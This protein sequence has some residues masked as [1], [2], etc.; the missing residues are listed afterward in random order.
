MR[1]TLLAS[2]VWHRSNCRIASRATS[3]PVEAD[4]GVRGTTSRC[5]D[6]PESVLEFVGGRSKRRGARG[7]TGALLYV[8]MQRLKVLNLELLRA[9]AIVA[10]TFLTQTQFESGECGLASGQRPSRY[11]AFDVLQ[12]AQVR[13]FI[14]FNRDGVR[15]LMINM[16][17]ATTGAVEA[18]VC[19]S[20]RLPGVVFAVHLHHPGQGFKLRATV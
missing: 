4:P 6:E 15:S 5:R 18:Y 17:T 9:C 3:E 1:R 14:W 20:L 13:V 12:N 7:A 10:S 2:S 16:F 8:P 11:Q 19:R